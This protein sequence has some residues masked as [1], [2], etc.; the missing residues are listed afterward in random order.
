MITKQK[1]SVTLYQSQRTELKMTWTAT[2]KPFQAYS[3]PANRPFN[4]LPERIT[5][6]EGPRRIGQNPMHPNWKLCHHTGKP[7][8]FSGTDYHAKVETVGNP[9]TTYTESWGANPF[10][11]YPW[12]FPAAPD[13]PSI[14]LNDLYKRMY[15]DLAG[16][17]DSYFL[18]LEDL[19]GFLSG[20][21]LL[22]TVK[23]V[24]SAAN[25][26]AVAVAQLKRLKRKFGWRTSLYQ[27]W[28]RSSELVREVIGLRLGYRFA[29]KAT[30]NDIVEAVDASLA[31]S[32]DVNRLSV[33]NTRHVMHYVK[34]F[35]ASNRNT[36]TMSASEFRNHFAECFAQKVA[37]VPPAEVCPDATLLN[38]AR[39]SAKLHCWATVRY[40]ERYVTSAR[41]MQ[42]RFGLDKP[43]ST[44]WAIVPCSFLI[45]YLMN[46]QELA[47]NADNA[48]NEFDVLVNI[49]DAW[50][51]TSRTRTVGIDWPGF[52]GSASSSGTMS[53]WEC[54]PLVARK[55]TSSEFW[56]E[57]VPSAV[58]M[59]NSSELIR[60]DDH[61]WLQ[62]IGTGLELLLSR[63]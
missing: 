25:K 8:Q 44:L 52:I 7:S 42:S 56:R 46:V 57:P 47:E 62:R 15:S 49:R 50:L 43:L 35:N 18:S 59:A 31:L 54:P 36:K 29:F 12:Q 22:K 55:T 51:L 17:V 41:I 48:L 33:R 40:P 45:D 10:T 19:A 21:S 4:S 32:T 2:G 30:L 13:M 11:G 61:S 63:R 37:V 3:Y 27:M 39:C 34:E 60:T 28:T 26:C 16:R 58:I 9:F 1:P 14:D 38:I 5:Y 53:K 6:A 20:E 24:A 23:S